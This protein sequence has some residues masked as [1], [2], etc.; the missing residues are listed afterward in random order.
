M[1]NN[2]FSL[3]NATLAKTDASTWMLNKSGSVWSN[4]TIAVGTIML[5]ANNALCP[6][7]KL[8]MGQSDA[9]AAALDLNGFNQW[10]QAFNPVAGTGTR[11]IGNNST[12]ADSVFTYD[13]GTNMSVF[14]GQFV[15]NLNTNGNRKLSLTVTSGTLQLTKA[16]TYTGVTTISGGTLA[17]GT[18]GSLA[19]PLIDLQGGAVLDTSALV[20]GLGLISGQTL[21]GN[22]TVQGSLTVGPGAMVSAGASIGALNITNGL[23]MQ[24]GSTNVFELNLGAG[25][26]DV[27]NAAVVTYGGTLQ[28]NNL[29]GPLA[30][31][32]T[33][34]LFY[35]AAYAGAF[36]AIVPA[37]PGTG[38][39][40]DVSQLAVTGTLGV[41]T[42]TPSTPTNI[43]FTVS[44]STLTLNWP[45]DYLGW[46]AQSNSV[47]VADTNFWFDIPGSSAATSL[48]ITI[49]PG[50]PKVFYRLRYQP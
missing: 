1:I 10:L 19:S 18:G 45:S 40:W 37:T 20:S 15:D 46:T 27:V 21:K 33:F 30:L 43:T 13:G 16:N 7:A 14:A 31:G 11:R 9:Q 32:N 38:L 25:T 39:A 26:N 41:K 35:A 24:T 44:G 22:G 2:T 28:L 8:L 12:N 29:G 48:N 4:S 34:K 23:A 49:D 17:I 42:G 36:D 6:T 3:P 5:G 47:N 50:T